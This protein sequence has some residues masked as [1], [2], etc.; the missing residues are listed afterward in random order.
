MGT[1]RYGGEEFEFS[2]RVLTHM[3]VVISAKLRRGENFFFTW[4]VP[5]EGGSGRHALWIDNGVPIHFFYSGSRS[6]GINRE[7]LES[8][9][10]S[11][12]RASGLLLTEEPTAPH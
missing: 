3:Q 5:A 10:A 6:V 12:S 2:D 8:L 1:L 7:W 11:A 4:P 9:I